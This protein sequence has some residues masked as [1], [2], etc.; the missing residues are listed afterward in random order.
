MSSSCLVLGHQF[1]GI[2]GTV[3][4]LALGVVAGAGMI[5]ADDEVRAAVVLADDG[6]PD[7]LARTGHAHGQVQQ[8]QRR[9]LLRVLLEHVLVAAHAGVVVDIAG[10]GQADHRVD[11]QVGLALARGTEGQFLVSAMQRVARLER[12]DLAPAELAEAA[13]QFG[14]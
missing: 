10:L 5:A 11:Q 14:G 12:H 13:A 4:R 1:L 8:R 3:E 9:G 2:V 6:V 7:G